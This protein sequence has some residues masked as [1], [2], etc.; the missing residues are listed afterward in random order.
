MN[1][2]VAQPQEVHLEQAEALAG[3]HVELGDDR[4]VRLA[5]AGSGVRR[6]SGSR[7]RM[8]PAACTPHW[9][10][11]PSR[12]LRGVDDLLHV[13]VG[14]VQRAELG[15]LR[16]ARVLRVEDA[17]QRDVLAHH[18]RRHRLGDPVAHRERVAEHPG[19]VLDRRL[20]LDRA[21]GD[22][23]GDPV[24]AVLLGDVADHVAAPALV[25]VHVD[26]GHGD[27]V[28]V[29]EPLEE[30]AVRH[31]VEL[32][33]AQRVGDQRAGGRAAARADPDALPLGVRDEVG[34]DQE[35][36]GEAHLED[37]V[38]LVLG[39]LPACSSGTPLGE[40]P[41]QPG[42]TSLRS[43][44]SSVSPA[45]TGNCGIRLRGAKDLGVVVDPLGDQ[46]GV[47]AGLGQLGA[48]GRAS[49]PADFR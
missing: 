29:E 12:P 7:D 2:E 8:T 48:T 9:R 6:C 16:V 28:R 49:R 22:D 35:V 4:A 47:V 26:V 43:Q 34:D 19:R 36:A 17:G 38:E 46:Q 40:P 45:G 20:R 10:L 25:E 23:L 27:A 3:G 1:G 42:A 41:L 5:L 44:D 13:G 15:R 21:V 24:V 32:G 33:D 14:L 18:R 37:D 30:Q 39:L 31:R 11:S